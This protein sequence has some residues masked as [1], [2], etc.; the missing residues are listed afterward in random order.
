VDVVTAPRLTSS[1]TSQVASQLTPAE[2]AVFFDQPAADQ[3]HGWEAACAVEKAGRPDLARAA[4]LHDVG[5]RQAGLGP[6]GRSL[7]TAWSK[8]GGAPRGR[9]RRYLDHGPAAAAELERLGAEPLVVDFARHHHG[10]RPE[11]IPPAAWEIL[12]RA[13]RA[14]VGRRRRG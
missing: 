1:E 2:A 11:S 7:A 3:R 6:V 12:V 13:D 4:L 8:L 9:W 10:T 14:R 5:K